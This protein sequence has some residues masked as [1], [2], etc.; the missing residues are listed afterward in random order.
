MPLPKVKK[1]LGGR[2]IKRLTKT[3]QETVYQLVM[4][5]LNNTELFRPK[6]VAEQLLH[7]IMSPDAFSRHMPDE[8]ERI[9]QSVAFKRE[10]TKVKREFL[11]NKNH[12]YF[13][14]QKQAS[15][16][17]IGLTDH[18]FLAALKKAISRDASRLP[19]DQFIYFSFDVPEDFASVRQMLRNVLKAAD[20]EQLHKSVWKSDKDVSALLKQLVQ[21]AKVE[22]WASVIIGREF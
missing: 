7:H 11:Q 5:R 9:R 15:G 19:S 2:P 22:R 4:Q 12:K 20:F 1:S 3:E 21:A 6:T 13:Q 17:M 10:Y 16:L 14:E 18:G 8:L